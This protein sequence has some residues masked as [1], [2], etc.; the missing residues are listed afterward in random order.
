M[1]TRTKSRCIKSTEEFNEALSQAAE[2]ILGRLKISSA[3]SEKIKALRDKMAS[4]TDPLQA[5]E[6]ILMARLEAYTTK[7]REQLLKGKK[8]AKG[9]HGDYG[10]RSSKSVGLKEGYD[11]ARVIQLLKGADLAAECVVIKEVIDK[12]ALAKLSDERLEQLGLVR[13]EAETFF[14]K[15][16]A[17]APVDTATRG[18]IPAKS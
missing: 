3:T 17:E 7:H 5:T 9:T 14:F 2:V 16:K 11:E 8:S 13:N 1:T 4:L 15:P 18:T 12:K 10:F 6:D